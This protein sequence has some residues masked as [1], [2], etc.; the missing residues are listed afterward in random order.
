MLGGILL[1][2]DAMNLVVEVLSA[3]DFYSEANAKIF[4]AM[5]ELFRRSQPVDHVT[6]RESLV[7]SGKLASIGGDEYL[8]SLSNTIPSVSNIQSHARIVREKSV[9]RSLIQACHEVVSRGYGDYGP[10]EEFLDDSES[11]IFAVAKERARNPYEHVKDV[12]MR[13]FQEIH[14]AANRGE[15]ITGLPTGYKKLD[16]MTAGMH[17]GDLIIVAGRPAMGKTSFALNVAHNACEK[18]KAPVAVFS[19]E[20]PKGQLVRRLLGS[21]ALSLIHI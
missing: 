12:V 6:L 7:H 8:L 18:T 15:A 1:E 10:I 3:D 21:Q 14:E 13:T 20:M 5:T 17:P 19:L 9:V 16:E 4:D 11:S 2:N